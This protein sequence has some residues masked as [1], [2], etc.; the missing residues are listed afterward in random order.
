MIY[1]R[2]AFVAAST[3]SALPPFFYVLPTER[4]ES[5]ALDHRQRLS[6]L[7]SLR[8]VRLF[9]LSL[10]LLCASLSLYI[11]TLYLRVTSACH[12]LLSST[13]LARP[14]RLHISTFGRFF[15]V[16]RGRK[17]R[18]EE[19]ERKQKGTTNSRRESDV[20]LYDR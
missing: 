12:F 10:S 5:D 2:D 19:N 20:K 17:K 8:H 18:E 4:I 9:S 7:R 6:S 3:I 1:R 13:P 15:K 16:R 11:V 14:G